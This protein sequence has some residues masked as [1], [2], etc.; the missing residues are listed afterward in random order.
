MTHIYFKSDNITLWLGDCR[1]ISPQCDLIV[2]DPPYGKDTVIGRYSAKIENDADVKLIRDGILAS[3]KG[4]K[5]SRHVYL[6]GQSIEDME[7]PIAK[8]VELIWD[9]ELFG[10]GDLEIPW[11]T[12]HEKI[13]FGV[14]EPS[15][16]NRE[17]GYGKLAA[18][19]RRGSVLRSIRAN[20]RGVRNHP[21]EKPVDIL[22]MMI[23]SSS[24]IGEAVYDPFC[25]SG[26]TIVASALEGRIGI[27]CEIL[28]K[29]C[30]RAVERF[31]E[32]LTPDQIGVVH[33][34]PEKPIR[35]SPQVGQ[36]SLFDGVT[37]LNSQPHD[38]AAENQE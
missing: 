28:E 5:R 33:I 10:L 7:L 32:E 21:T 19:M 8:T 35:P 23:E 14:Y 25:G 4:L 12:Q 16:K 17:N 31:Y 3:L 9:K 24:M 37:F 22:R 29:Y 30:K 36:A 2:S 13:Q 34:S 27:G 15:K 1:D 18:R 11:G 20:S 6:F 26:S 38:A